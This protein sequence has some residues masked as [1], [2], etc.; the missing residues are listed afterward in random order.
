MRDD[1][2]KE[3]FLDHLNYS[4][5]FRDFYFTLSVSSKAY[6]F[7]IEVFVCDK[8]EGVVEVLNKH[9]DGGWFFFIFYSPSLM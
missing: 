4:Q 7:L 3:K 9:L 5:C 8:V 6:L 1:K 2:F